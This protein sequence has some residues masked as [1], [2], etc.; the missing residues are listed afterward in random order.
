MA[1]RGTSLVELL[2][3]LQLLQVVGTAALATAFL[4]TR[5]AA[6]AQ[7]GIATDRLRRD[8]VHGIAA[9]PACRHAVPPTT[10]DLT[11]P[12]TPERP[13]LAVRLR[14]GGVSLVELLVTLT[15]LGLVGAIA[16]TILRGTTRP[17]AAITVAADAGRTIDALGALAARESATP[18]GLL[19]HPD[20]PATLHLARYVGDAPACAATGAQVALALDRWVGER[21]PDAS[22]DGL[23]IRDSLGAWHPATP[24]ASASGTCPD[25]TPALWWTLDR[26]VPTG[27]AV[28]HEPTLVRAYSGVG[29][30]WLGLVGARS[31]APIQPFAGPLAGD[32]LALVAT[33]TGLAAVVRPVGMPDVTVPLATTAP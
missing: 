25:G 13:A 27:W 4:A 31:T 9:A 20:D 5:L 8:A 33:A 19:A 18:T 1:R 22:R 17:L 15:L 28:V 11:L 10:L 23:A 12:A 6:R 30:R 24:T 16:V 14:C 26:A 7:R 3:A 21:L 2:V 29:G 32:G